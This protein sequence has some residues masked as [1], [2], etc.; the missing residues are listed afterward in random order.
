MQG[1]IIGG[2]I[3]G[4]TTAI[5]LQQR[6]IDAHVYEQAPEIREVG[7]GLIMAA[8]AMQVLAWLGLAESIQRTGWALQKGFITRPDGAAIQTVDVGALSRRYGFGMV[9]IQRG[10]L[11]TIL[12]N[13]L[14]ADRV[15]TGKRLVDLY[16]NGERVRVTFADGSTAEGDFVIGAD[17]IRSVV[18]QQLFGDQPLRYSGQTCWR[19]LV[20]LPLPTETQTTSYEYWGL[21]AGLRVGLVPLGADQLYVYVTAASPAGQLAPNSLPT[22]LSLS[23]SFA[24][25]VKAVLEQFEENRIHRADL[26]DLPTLPTWSTG[27]V[28]LLGDAAHA[29]T[30]NLGQGACQAIE[31]AWAVAACLYRYQAPDEAFRQFQALR[32][33]KADRI[34]QVSR[35]IGQ[36]VNAPGWLKPFLFAA[37]G[38]LPKSLT[39]RQFAEIYDVTYL[40]AIEKATVFQSPP[41]RAGSRLPAA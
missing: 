13:S 25:P 33:P 30:P 20:D 31:D 6:G 3:G 5:A 39:D 41:V 1:I 11:Q 28:T 26:Y 19:G 40:R 21:P 16:D 9:A 24:P 32:K 14:P 15:H 2:G 34:V 18:R 27:R 17:G 37:M 4:L 23:Q 22:L 12:L 38:A 10:L 29:T 7:A 8:N 35:Q 36:A